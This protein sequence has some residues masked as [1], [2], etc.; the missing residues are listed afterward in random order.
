MLVS[1]SVAVANSG[2]RLS[3]VD[4]DTKFSKQG[5]DAPVVPAGSAG[6]QYWIARLP[7]VWPTPIGATLMEA[8]RLGRDLFA[9]LR[10]QVAD[11]G[12]RVAAVAARVFRKGSLPSLAQRDTVLGDT[13][14]I[15][16]TSP[17]RR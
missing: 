8:G 15:S 14:R 7:E 1:C 10:G 13:D 5:L 12:L 17:V 9:K 3:Q 11:L 4:A 16:A 6:S 2:A